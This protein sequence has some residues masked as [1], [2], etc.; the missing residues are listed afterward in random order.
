[1]NTFEL[2]LRTIR[3]RARHEMSDGAVTEGYKADR[4]QVI[5]VLNQVLATELVC[6]MRYRNH[7]YMAQGIRGEVAA[8]EFWEHAQDE[9][10]HA[11]MVAERIAQLN[12]NPDFDPEGLATRS[13]AEYREHPE[14]AAMIEENL[15][16]ERVAIGT[17]SEIVRWLGDA[18]PT[19]RRMMEQILAQEEEHADD[20]AGM[21]AS[22]AP[23]TRS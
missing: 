23:S 4:E 18:D 13:H 5:A 11:D 20:M 14:L 15:V 21:L 16:A 7:Y 6:N 2:D 10:R 3:E 1:M 17:Y 22:I 19:T 12:G 9:A 8:D